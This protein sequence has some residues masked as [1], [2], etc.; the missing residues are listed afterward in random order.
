MKKQLNWYKQYLKN[1]I[2]SWKD[3]KIKL[4]EALNLRKEIYTKLEQA[5]DKIVKKASSKLL[6]R[7][8]EEINKEFFE[9]SE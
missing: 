3:A 6:E 7:K 5:P 4:E 2:I 1:D 8:D 9:E